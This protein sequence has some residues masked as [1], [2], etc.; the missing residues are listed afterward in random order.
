[1]STA[2]PSHPIAMNR[3]W[4]CGLGLDGL[5]EP[6]ADQLLAFA[7]ERLELAVGRRLAEQMTAAELDEFEGF[8]DRNDE[9]GALGWLTAHVP[10]YPQVVREELALLSEALRASASGL[11]SELAEEATG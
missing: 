3:A 9:P 6:D 1:M 11:R 8:I 10:E 4:L 7:R 2:A 5:P